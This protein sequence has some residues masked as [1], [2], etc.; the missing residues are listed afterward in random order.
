MNKAMHYNLHDAS[1]VM[2]QSMQPVFEYTTADEFIKS[3]G[4]R[5]AVK[6]L[7]GEALKH[8]NDAVLKRESPRILQCKDNM[9]PSLCNDIKMVAS[10]EGSSIGINVDNAAMHF[11]RNEA[12]DSF[13]SQLL[14]TGAFV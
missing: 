13:F 12:T 2:Q 3:Y 9:A 7:V 4:W 5:K 1:R 10:S 11:E 8:S 14:N 6:G